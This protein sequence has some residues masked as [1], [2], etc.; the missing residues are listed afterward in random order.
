MATVTI[1]IVADGKRAKLS[2]DGK[3]S[4][5]LKQWPPSVID[6]TAR[7]L[8]DLLTPANLLLKASTVRKEAKR[9]R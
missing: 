6:A 1:T 9:A 3:T 5:E 7:K 8:K 2:R 4:S